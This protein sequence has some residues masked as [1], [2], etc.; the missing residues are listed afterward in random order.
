MKFIPEETVQILLQS[1]SFRFIFKFS[2]N[3]AEHSCTS[4]LLFCRDRYVAKS[5]C[6]MVASILKFYTLA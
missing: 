1:Y 2:W 3:S 4:T 6:V 5:L